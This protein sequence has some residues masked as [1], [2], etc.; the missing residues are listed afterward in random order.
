MAVL[1][2]YFSPTTLVAGENLVALILPSNMQLQ[3]ASGTATVSISLT[4][5]GQ[6]SATRYLSA[7]VGL[8]PLID[9]SNPALPMTY[10]PLMYVTH[11]VT[12][13]DFPLGGIWRAQVIA[14]FPSGVVRK[15]ALQDL[16]IGYAIV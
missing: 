8:A 7:I 5:P 16:P 10:Q 2:I 11:S 6:L 1:P 14:T 3:D 4:E 13:V 12:S 9:V 15:S